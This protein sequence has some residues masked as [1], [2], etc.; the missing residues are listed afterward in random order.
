M[1]L[2]FNITASR[3]PLVGVREEV[4]ANTILLVEDDIELAE[5]TKERLGREGFH[6]L[7]EENGELARNLII[8]EQ[9]DLVVL[10][11]MLPGFDG[12]EVCRQVRPQYAGPIL[13]LT[14]RDDNLDEILGLELGADDFVTKPV[15]PRLL[16]ARIRALLRRSQRKNAPSKTGKVSVGE[17][18][19][20]GSRR[21]AEIDGSQ[22][23]LTTIEF[24]LLSYLTSRAGEVV[25]RQEI[26]QALFR[27]DYDGLDRSV[28]VYISRLRQK[29]GD[30][31][32]APHY[33]KTVRGVG[34]LMA[35]EKT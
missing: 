26:Y 13:I 35:G 6:V 28:D 19:V 22:V 12:F 17:L 24:D 10:D 34:Y 31:P 14:A 33:I 9:P 7:Q 4:E 29:L 2:P 15:N 3:T 32:G 16:L 5:L 8:K 20:D 27:Y 25:S 30:N 1:I 18:T 21:E 23:E 11:I